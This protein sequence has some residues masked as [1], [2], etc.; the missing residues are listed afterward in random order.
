MLSTVQILNSSQEFILPSDIANRAYRPLD[1]FKS[2]ILRFLS[3][4]RSVDL[5]PYLYMRSSYEG[6][7]VRSDQL[8]FEIINDEGYYLVR[9]EAELISEHA[10]SIAKAIGSNIS[11]IELGPGTETAILRKTLPLLK[12]I[13]NLKSYSPVDLCPTYLENAIRVVGRHMPNIFIDGHLSDF[14][15]GNTLPNKPQNPFVF[16][17]GGTIGNIP[18]SFESPQHNQ[19]THKLSQLKR[20]LNPEGFLLISYDS[21]QDEASLMAAYDNAVFHEYVLNI[22]HLI[23]RDLNTVGLDPYGFKVET[24]WHQDHYCL[25]SYAVA[26]KSQTVFID[27]EKIHIHKG[28]KMH[29]C[30]SYKFP[31]EYFTKIAHKAGYKTVDTF[32]SKNG[33]MALQLLK[34]K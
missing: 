14:Y 24:V 8:Y 3:G 22:F 17:P 26:T 13:K 23:N 25:A 30:S 31:R 7:L 28:H 12:A 6:D 5:E 32:M 19:V 27:K 29:V 18:G 33:R 2:S 11:L 1:P 21:N 20:L 4:E 16:F 9:E 10:E 34:I 15:D